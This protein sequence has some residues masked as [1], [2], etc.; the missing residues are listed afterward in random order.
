M[1]GLM[2]F[3]K[4]GN[5]PLGGEIGGNRYLQGV[6][7]AP[8]RRTVPS[9]YHGRITDPVSGIIDFY[10]G[11]LETLH[12]SSSTKEGRLIHEKK[13]RDMI[14]D[15]LLDYTELDA[16]LPCPVVLLSK[17]YAPIGYGGPN[18]FNAVPPPHMR[19]PPAWLPEENI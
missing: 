4:T 17:V 19:G 2:A 7:P 15:R 18:G 1:L 11:A 10:V 16:I 8:C 13:I 6:L 5:I 14:S 3:A 12:P 9:V